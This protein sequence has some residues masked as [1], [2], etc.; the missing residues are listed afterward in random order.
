M[1]NS[2]IHSLI[3]SFPR[4]PSYENLDPKC[5]QERDPNDP[6]CCSVPRCPTPLPQHTLSPN[7]TASAVTIPPG[8][9]TGDNSPPGATGSTITGECA[10]PRQLVSCDDKW[11][12]HRPTESV[13]C[14]QMTVRHLDSFLCRQMLYQIFWHFVSCQVK[15]VCHSYILSSVHPYSFDFRHFPHIHLCVKYYLLSGH[16]GSCSDIFSWKVT[17][18]VSYCTP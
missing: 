14:R 1:I 9:V 10:S 4:C 5:T 18:I 8:F 15:L 11:R 3:H 6:A 13:P 12:C 17:Q 16:T 2:L 7:P